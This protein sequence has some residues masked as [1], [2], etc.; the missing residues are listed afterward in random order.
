MIDEFPEVQA[1]DEQRQQIEAD[2]VKYL[3]WHVQRLAEHQAAVEAH[4][5]AV[6]EA[7]A[8]ELPVTS[9]P[10]Q[11]LDE[12][13]HHQRIAALHAREATL[14]EDRTRIVAGLT[15]RVRERAH[16]RCAQL[17]NEVAEPLARLARVCSEIQQLRSAV[18][19]CAAAQASLD[20][21]DPSRGAPRLEPFP[22]MTPETL[23]AAYTHGVDLLEIRG[24]RRLGFSAN[25][26]S[27][28]RPPPPGTEPKPSPRTRRM[29]RP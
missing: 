8:A 5:V 20:R 23:I 4:R 19:E 26:I 9:K 24:E 13:D 3:A 1:L 18:F 22:A 27:E 7:I 12:S 17:M 6:D 10:P 11:P 29:L 25:N 14:S 28:M 15:S 16:T 2:R 21:Q